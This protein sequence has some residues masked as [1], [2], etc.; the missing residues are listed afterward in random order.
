MA[1]TN[2]TTIDEYIGAFPPEVQSVLQEIRQIIHEAVPEAEE[3]I[4]YQIPAFKHHGM[5]LYFS[6]Y[7]KHSAIASTPDTIE[8]FHDEISAYKNSKSSFQIPYTEP[9]PRDL[10]T[11]MARW[12]AAENANKA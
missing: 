10:I 6:A 5:V 4:S 7:A 11:R 2:Y 12:R 8:H 9:L 1:K 3:V